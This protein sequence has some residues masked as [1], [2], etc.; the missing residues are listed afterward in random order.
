MTQDN[1]LAGKEVD[2]EVCNCVLGSHIE[3]SKGSG[4]F[5][6]KSE[7]D[8]EIKRL[9]DAWKAFSQAKSR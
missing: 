6:P 8:L 3:T 7:V 2:F 5:Y 1:P 4:E 9:Q